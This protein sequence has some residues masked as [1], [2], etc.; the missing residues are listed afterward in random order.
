M[1][2]RH[3]LVIAGMALAASAAFAQGTYYEQPRYSDQQ[4]QDDQQRHDA[5][6]YSH[7]A[8][9]EQRRSAEQE[10][11]IRDG[12][13]NGSITPREAA[14]LLDQQREI[15]HVEWRANHDGVLTPDERRQIRYLQDRADRTIDRME[16]NRHGY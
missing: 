8:W 5:N 1:F 15:R 9:R 4:Q 12:Q 10:R 13:A 7:A 11:R 16:N 6:G 2:N 3:L 14:Y